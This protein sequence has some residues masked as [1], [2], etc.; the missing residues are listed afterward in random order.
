MGP[1]Q[2]HA[3]TWSEAVKLTPEYVAH[4]FWSSLCAEGIEATL[5]TSTPHKE[6]A[7]GRTT[8]PGG[9]GQGPD[10]NG[11]TPAGMSGSTPRSSMLSISVSSSLLR[12]SS[13]EAA[14][15]IPPPCGESKGSSSLLRQGHAQSAENER[16][17][18]SP[19]RPSRLSPLSS[20]SSSSKERARKVFFRL[21]RTMV[22][23][24]L[25]EVECD[26]SPSEGGVTTGFQAQTSPEPLSA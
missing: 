20:S 1:L 5:G 3:S 22:T 10:G 19:S 26:A 25:A 13:C 17:E 7:C 9:N 2:M 16:Q 4:E 8:S 12:L 6:W 23:P 11:A 14:R 18:A 15:Q 24:W 21:I